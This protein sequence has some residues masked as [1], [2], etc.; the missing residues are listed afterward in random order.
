M[1]MNACRCDGVYKL[2]LYQARLKP[3]WIRRLSNDNSSI[4]V[5]YGSIEGIDPDKIAYATQ[6]SEAAIIVVNEVEVKADIMRENYKHTDENM[7]IGF[8][9][10]SIPNLKK[11]FRDLS[12]SNK[13]YEHV[14]VEF[15]VKHLFFD[16]LIKSVNK[17][18]PIIAQRLLPEPQDFLLKSSELAFFQQDESES[19]PIISSQLDP[20]DQLNALKIIAQS[21]AQSPPILINGSFGTG[22]TRVLAFAAYYFTEVAVKPTR[23]LI[24]AHHQV[25]A[26]H[27][28]ES[29]FGEMIKNNWHV[30]LI[31]L[32][33]MNYN[34]RN[35]QYSKFF[36][37]FHQLH[38]EVKVGRVSTGSGNLVIATTFLTALRLQDLFAP[39]F[40]THILLDEGAQTREAEA[41]TPLSLATSETKIV[42]A[43]DSCQVSGKLEII[44]MTDNHFIAN[45]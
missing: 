33:S 22:K 40:F 2:V 23:V 12:N 19:I 24:C 39:G 35:P 4:Y 41:I 42:I 7:Y 36:M 15:E 37:N 45:V 31:R 29:Y 5:R 20:D 34:A 9:Q 18:D 16:N 3:Q 32:T 28:V 25:S 27:F 14:K 6:A 30:R 43:G 10:E 26:D 8:T 38:K 44:V 13:T 1:C 17:I 11:A 21:P